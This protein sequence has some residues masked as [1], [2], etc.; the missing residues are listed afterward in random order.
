MGLVVIRSVAAGEPQWRCLVC[1]TPFYDGEMTAYVR[2]VAG[3]VGQVGCHERHEDELRAQSLR[4]KAPALFD[5]FVS[6]DVELGRWIKAY[7]PAILSG[8]MKL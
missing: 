3:A 6:G 5:P 2:H 8:R 4:V 7:G 1:G